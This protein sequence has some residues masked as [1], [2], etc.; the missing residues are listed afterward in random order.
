MYCS[1]HGG[2]FTH[3]LTY[4]G[5]PAACA[6]GLATLKILNDTNS[7]IETAADNR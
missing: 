2:E 3:G 5:H 1:P 7:I 4:S 6:A